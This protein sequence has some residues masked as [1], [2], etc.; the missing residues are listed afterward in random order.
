MNPMTPIQVASAVKADL[1]NRRV[2]QKQLAS[3][4]GISQQWLAKLLC[5][6]NYISETWALRLED[7]LGYNPEFLMTGK[8]SLIEYSTDFES[9]CNLV[10]RMRILQELERRASE[11]WERKR[12]SEVF[13][14]NEKQNE[15]ANLRRIK[16][17]CFEAVK[18][19]EMT[20]GLDEKQL[21]HEIWKRESSM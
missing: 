21:Y 3:D 16:A 7:I 4:V 12:Q 13:T 19:V 14:T 17:E 10:R 15:L 2:T 6:D 9:L 18:N 11:R 8:G 1:K 20:V 5:G